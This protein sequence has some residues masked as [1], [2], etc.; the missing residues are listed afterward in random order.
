MSSS[1]IC[2]SSITASLYLPHRPTA[3][4][5]HLLSNSPVSVYSA[6]AG[7]QDRRFIQ[8]GQCRAVVTP[9]QA[10]TPPKETSYDTTGDNDVFND[11]AR[12]ETR[13]NIRPSRHQM[14]HL[15]QR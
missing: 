15:G 12:N 2:S 6:G 14:K 9:S 1:G 8:R 11:R 3:F 4:I 13:A 10:S 7:Y 5:A